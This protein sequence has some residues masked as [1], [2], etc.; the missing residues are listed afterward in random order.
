MN[1]K[2][3]MFTNMCLGVLKWLD[4][5]FNIQSL[6]LIVVILKNTA[7][8]CTHYGLIMIRVSQ[9][10]RENNHDLKFG[11]HPISPFSSHDHDR[12]FNVIFKIMI[13]SHF[14]LTII[15]KSLPMQI[16]IM[17]TLSCICSIYFSYQTDHDRVVS[18]K[19]EIMIRL[20]TH[21]F[22]FQLTIMIELFLS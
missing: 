1:S 22:I 3:S 6:N 8:I 21:Q 7:K 20:C 15:I 14:G 18:S 2:F 17:I 19:P 13:G 16:V 11:I 10:P 12:S 9:F 4:T 5:C